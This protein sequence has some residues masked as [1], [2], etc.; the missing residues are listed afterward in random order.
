MVNQRRRRTII[1]LI[2]AVFI[3]VCQLPNLLNVFQPWKAQ[4]RE[5]VNKRLTQEQTDL[6][7]SLAAGEITATEFQRR[8]QE[9]VREH[10]AEREELDRQTWQQVQHTARF[11]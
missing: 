4:Q 8:Q 2:T 11:L 7:R 3:L 5:E 1:V 9:I 6:Q 10:K